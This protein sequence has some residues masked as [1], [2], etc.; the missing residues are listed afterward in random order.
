[1]R[2]YQG[3]RNLRRLREISRVLVKYGFGY[4]AIQLGLDRLI[5]VSRWR[6][7]L[8]GRDHPLSPA[9][10]LRMALGELGP[11]FTKLGQVLSSRHD[12]LPPQYLTELRKLQDAAPPVPYRQIESE[13]CAELGRPPDELFGSIEPEPLSSASIGQ[14]HGATTRDGRAVVVKVQRPDIARLVETDLAIMWDAANFLHVRSRA[15]RRFDLPALA[16][17]FTT[18][19]RDE[20]RYRIEAYNAERLREN[21]SAIEWVQ[22]PAVVWELTTERVLAMERVNGLRIDRV[23]EL[24]EL[25]IDLPDLARR[26]AQCMLQQVFV[27]GFFHGDPHQGNVWVREDG[28]LVLLDFGTMGRLDQRFRRSLIALILALARQDTEAALDEIAEMGMMGEHQ[29]V[30]GLRHD[31]RRLFTRYYFLPR[32]E[33]PLGE[34]LIRVVQLMSTHRTPVPWEFSHLGKALVITEGICHELDPDF[35]FDDAA[36]PIAEQL[37]RERT[38]AR[39]IADELADFGRDM[40]RN[41]GALPERINQV[42]SELRRGTLRVRISDE[43][44]ERVLAHQAALSSRIALSVILAAL[45]VADSLFLLSPVGPAAAK[46]WVGIPVLAATGLAIILFIAGILAPRS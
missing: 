35:D 27:D 6:T 9:E 4:V 11:T 43:E 38:S 29:D 34:L 46:L 20:L 40:A 17:E 23:D 14:V 36:A 10:R 24:G 15:L 28:T 22:V 26:F 13:V 39:Y 42:L 33:F 16:A 5:P 7:R 18:I 37:R 12:L 31:L 21:L 8:L 19:M 44:S 45:V 1:M 3:L 32:R 2:L 25:G 41:L 30:S